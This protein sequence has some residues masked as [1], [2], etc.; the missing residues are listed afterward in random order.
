VITP[1][2]PGGALVLLA[3]TS[4]FWLFKEVKQPTGRGHGRRTPYTKVEKKNFSRPAH[5]EGQGDVLYRG[6]QCLNPKCT[7]F[8]FVKDEDITDDFDTLKG[9]P[10]F[11]PEALVG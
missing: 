3:D 6:F 5:V 11:N 9:K 8:I 4:S 2:R 7:N 10:H 1:Q